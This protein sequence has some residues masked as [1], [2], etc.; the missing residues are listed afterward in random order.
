MNPRDTKVLN[1]HKTIQRA[2]GATDILE[3]AK[4][5]TT[6]EDAIK[7]CDIVIGTGMPIDM[8]QKRTRREYTEP[9]LYFEQLLNDIQCE[10]EASYIQEGPLLDVAFLF[11]CE[12]TGMAEEDMDKCLVMLGIPTNPKFGSLNLASAVQIIAYDWRM[13]LGGGDSYG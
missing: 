13:A 4:L 11:G 6:V 1:R 7:G 5:Y 8:Y 10:K 3:N 2:S 9:R 12:T